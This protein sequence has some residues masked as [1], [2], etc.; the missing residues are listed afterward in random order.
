MAN[1]GFVGSTLT[2]N[3]QAIGAIR[4]ISYSVDGGSVDVTSLSNSTHIS[5]GGIKTVECTVELVGDENTYAAVGN[6]GALSIAWFS[7]DTDGSEATNFRVSRRSTQ[8]SMDGEITTSVTFV[9]TA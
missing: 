5:V 1:D 4:S 7:G 6:T 8:G 2:F 9:P 3:S